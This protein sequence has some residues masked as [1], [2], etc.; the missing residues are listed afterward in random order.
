MSTAPRR[1]VLS[2]WQSP[3]DLLMLSAA[4]RDLHLGYP[5][6]FQTDIRTSCDM[7][8]DNSPYI[9]RFHEPWISEVA[10]QARDSKPPKTIDRDGI[11][12]IPCEYPLVHRSNQE[13]GHF[14][15][16]F[17]SFLADALGLKRIWATSF[18]GEICLSNDEKMWTNQVAELGVRDEFWII[19]TGGKW[20]FTSKWPN[21]KTLQ[22][23]VDHFYRKIIFVQVGDAGN[24]QPNLRGVVN[25]V[26]HTDLRQ[27]I[28]LM[29]HSSGVLCPVNGIMHLAAA[30]PT[31]PGWPERP[32]VILAGAREPTHWEAYPTHRYLTTQGAVPCGT[33]G[34]CWRSRA[35]L[36]G[37]GDE[38]DNPQ[39]ACPN[40]VEITDLPPSPMC[41]KKMTSIRVA[42][43]IDMIKAEDIISAIRSY[44]VGGVLPPMMTVPA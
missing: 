3:G 35:T 32:A 23:V 4:I 18:K 26:G 44:Y 1:I 33:P 9:T 37:D 21:P 17:H 43:C 41:R 12:V 5:G 13:S 10:A 42:Q 38:K 36:V 39:A 20:D 31:R 2:N 16:A 6:Q 34:A 30:I 11:T 27:L 15:H 24:W 25:L 22:K 8:W 7:L 40:Y 29:Y 28:R 19:N 14:V